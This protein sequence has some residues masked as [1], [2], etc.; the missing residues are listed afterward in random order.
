MEARRVIDGYRAEKE[1]QFQEFVKTVSVGGAISCASLARPSLLGFH[2]ICH[3]SSL[4]PFVAQPT[5][6]GHIV[7]EHSHFY[8]A[9][10]T[11]PNPFQKYGTSGSQTAD[12]D[13]QTETE[14]A[15]LRYGIVPRMYMNPFSSHDSAN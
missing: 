5:F 14:L 7:T 8:P 11:P 13:R 4:L 10:H 6:E 12:L 3:A 9:L 15:K 2:L 1:E